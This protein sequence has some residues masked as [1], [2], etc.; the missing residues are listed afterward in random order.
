MATI[1]ALFD[2]SKPINRRIE[3]VITYGSGSEDLLKLE[4]QEY[5]ATDNIEENLSNLL[6]RL[7]EGMSGD[8]GNVE[9]GVWVS[10]FY[11]SGKSSFTKYLGFA[12]DPHKQLDG[13]PFAHHLQNQLKSAPI[14]QRLATVAKKH[15]AAVVMLN[16]AGEQLAGAT[17]AEI[18]TVLYAKVMQWA[19][20]SRDA[21]IAYLE[22][23]LEKDGKLDAFKKAVEEKSN[24]M[25][26]DDLK[27]QP[28]ATKALASRVAP[29][30]YPNYF[31][32]SKTFND[33]KMEELMS[34]D[35]RVRHMIELITRKAGTDKIILIIDEVGN[36]VAGRRELITNLD[37]LAKNLKNIGAGK[38][39]LIATA[40]QMLT[41]DDPR[42]AV[43]T[44]HLG[45][46]K[47]RFPIRV[48][49]QAS[50]IK[51]I[52]YSRLLGKSKAGAETLVALFDAF[53][54][55]LRH[56]VKLENT[57]YY[58]SDLDRDAFLKYY[59]FLPHHFEILLRLLGRLAKSR[60][61]V[62]LRSAI[63]VIQ[64]VLVEHPA[65]RQNEPLF[66]D[67][68]AGALATTVLFYDTLRADI[69][70]PFPH[71]IAG[72]DKVEK[73]FGPGSLQSDTAKS[74][75]VLQIL[76]DFP[77]SRANVAAMMHTAVT[78]AS[79]AE[80]VN[81][82]VDELL[83]D[84]AVPL[85]EVD[86]NLRFMSE[87]V[88]DLEGEK[89]RITPRSMDLRSIRNT[90]LR[91]LFSPTPSVKLHGTRN[92]GTGIKIAG[93]GMP[94]SLSGD[95]EPVQTVIAF[96]GGKEYAKTLDQ[97]VE[98]SRHKSSADTIYLIGH[99]DTDIDALLTEIHRCREIYKLHRNS[100][101]DKEVEEYLR[102]QEQRADSLTRD[103]AA[104]IE[105]G[106]NAGSFI[107]RGRPVAVSESGQEIT[108][109]L[110]A[111]LAG[112]A[113]EV[114]NKYA[115][116]AHQAD[117]G[118]AERLLKTD[119]LDKI[120]AQDD[121]L[122]L[123]KGGA[124]DRNHKAI[125]SI[126][127]HLQQQGQVEGRRLLDDFYAAP[128]GWT[129][130]TT[131]YII[132]AMLVGG[133]VKLRVSGEDVTVSGETAV[134]S[135][136]NTN[137]FNGIGVALRDNA[138]PA[139]AVMRACDRLL[140]LTGDEVLPL[141]KEVSKCVVK[142]FPE[143]QKRYAPLSYRLGSSSLPGVSRA[144][145]I[146]D[147]LSALLRGDASDAANRLGGEYC[148]LADDLTW[149]RE[150]ADAYDKGFGETVGSARELLKGLAGLPATGVPGAL[151]MNAE[152]ECSD[153][154]ECLTRDDVHRQIPDIRKRN[155]A[156]EKEIGDA[157]DE[158]VAELRRLLAK[159]CENVRALPEW[160]ELGAE[161]REHLGAVLD[162]LGYEAPRTLQG[163]QSLMSAQYSVQGEIER[164]SEEVR[165]LGR[166][167]V[168]D[169]TETVELSAPRGTVSKEALAA[170]IEELNE[171]LVKLDAG[172][173]LYLSWK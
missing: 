83:S 9:I 76:E 148:P 51:E 26:W 34:E 49:L 35:Q 64:D 19:G 32:D 160:A 61:G 106:L 73:I 123:V 29:L 118:T 45:Q 112:V 131:R 138:P 100:A 139:E 63:K 125:V 97:S 52:C 44:Q 90:A 169:G 130:D 28:L 161:D 2:A 20:Y 11:G 133:L 16:L 150:T 42:A 163:I 109:A 8:S 88:L 154:T 58:K 14:R 78:A 23:M 155:A 57:K 81:K 173:Q 147:S 50:D 24:G 120:A 55:Q 68:Q 170:L 102:A 91:D 141:E 134:S 60:G 99:E 157:F 107:F 105:K 59:P 129:K 62:G 92:V 168:D 166:P 119:R 87:A 36:Y 56:A 158:F 103:L 5:V 30:F 12:L 94:V 152:Q 74:I 108:R 1:R 95:K 159:Q 117:S 121:P 156:L 165:T 39:W 167:D 84:A 171:L 47:D 27:N 22:A 89:L 25:S 75:A 48:D 7:D 72:V 104:R 82:V 153:L 93:G 114:F 38:V 116:A 70:K 136:R 140:S 132:A 4:I 96:A 43:N 33:I 127:N 54:P 18:S 37:G 110:N 122:V 13:K 3:K 143:F 79:R 85:N 111:Y 69:E 149:A 86:G 145:S 101:A 80:A 128:Y 126:T 144:E 65:G 162:A 53:G 10:G 164:I 6:D 77:V 135:L 41:E 17:L 146:Q 113:A 151:K 40:Q 98:E 67:E 71:I 142:H 172:A 66:A 115:E 137:G 31:P 124:V 15:Q 46:L 21:K